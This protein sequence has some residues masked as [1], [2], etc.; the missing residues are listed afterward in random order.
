[1]WPIGLSEQTNLIIIAFVTFWVA[2]CLLGRV[3]KLEDHGFEVKPFF[4]IYKT[5]RINSFLDYVSQR[6]RSSVKIFS[7][8]SIVLCFGMIAF[9][10]YFLI[11][12]IFALYYVEPT[13]APVFPV[14]PFITIT[15]SL[16][17]FFIS[18]AVLIVVHELA[19]GIVARREGIPV[20]SAGF[21]LIAILPGGF[22]EPDENGFKAAGRIKRI[23][24]LAAGSS[25]NLI[26]GIIMMIILAFA[27][28]SP[29]PTGVEIKN[30]LPD[31]PADVAG[32]QVGDIITSVGGKPTLG[33]EP[34]TEEMAKVAV[35]SPALLGIK[36]K[37][38]TYTE[39]LVATVA[40]SDEP[41]RAI[42][43]IMVAD[44]I[45]L[46]P[47]FLTIFWIQLLSINIAIFNALPIRYLD[48]DGI[49]YNLTEKYSERYAKTIRYGLTG[50]YLA[51]LAM[52]IVL[53]GIRFGF[54]SI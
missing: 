51:I 45:E 19:H 47:L 43:G 38:G 5:K 22:V 48:G 18:V 26:F 7:N 27:F 32:L 40:A 23:R 29:T 13:G 25:A 31:K 21:L 6:F 34:F 1:L 49:V 35:G 15:H 28:V 53:T 52:N 16:P 20:K 36:F 46:S 42:V 24:V 39:L 17:Y 3:L 8:I 44:Y 10:T 54:P 37:N 14:I 2:I 30:A 9:I 50:F 41:P 4:L 11:R 12:N 33:V